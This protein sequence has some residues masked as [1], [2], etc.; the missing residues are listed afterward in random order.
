MH[1]WMPRPLDV[2]AAAVFTAGT[3]AEVWA[4]VITGAPRPVLALATGVGTAAA[5]WHRIAPLG[6]LAVVLT[7]LVVAPAAIGAD[8]NT[9]TVWFVAA[10]AVIVSAGFHAGRPVVAL[11]LTLA[12]LGTAVVLAT[13]P[14]IEDVVYAWLL[15]TGAWL[16]GRTIASRT[17]RAALS[18]QRAL[19]AEQQ[20]DWRAATAVMDE[21]LR[22][23]RE[24]HDVIGHNISV[25][26]MHVG[27]VRR[28]L[29]PEQAGERAALEAVERTGREAL[30]E[31]RRLLGVLRAP[32]PAGAAPAP[33]LDRAAELLDAARAAGISAA[34]TVTGQARPLPAGLELA[35]YRIVQ[36]AVT[37]VLRHA[38]A[39]RIGCTTDYGPAAVGLWIVDDGDGGTGSRRSGHGHAGMRERVALYGGT[40]DI[41]PR[42]G[43]GYAVHAV[44]PVPRAAGAPAAAGAS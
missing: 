37:N 21:R 10:F 16:A 43:G 25:M 12:L 17:L 22:I 11:A 4:G 1:R 15:G 29:R 19:L 38:G 6:A 7:A 36:E 23:A 9:G 2:V 18:E 24:L 28:L 26:T 5:A 33:G 31:A 13:G 35:A 8:D 42:A 20:A 44:L 41:G 30:A 40:I 32:E 39:H 27:G 14:K 34:L 3:Q